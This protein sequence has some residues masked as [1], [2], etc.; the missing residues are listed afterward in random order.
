MGN[1]AVAKEGLSG[2][3]GDMAGDRPFIGRSVTRLEDPPLVAGRG[4]FAADISFA[5]QLHMRVVRSA[6]AHGRI[7]AIGTSSALASGGVV[8][9][10]S[11]GAVAHSSQI[12]FRVRRTEGLEP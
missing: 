7:V 3:P 6:H 12:G 9:A 4:R 8:G 2:M 1:D 11:G 10:W 5:H